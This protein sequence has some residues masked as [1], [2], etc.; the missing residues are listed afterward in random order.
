[1]NKFY[2]SELS[3]RN[4][5]NFYF[6]KEVILPILFLVNKDHK[7]IVVITEPIKEHGGGSSWARL[8]WD[9]L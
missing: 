3:R 7:K 6:L 2:L 1:M 8:Y 9:D 5:E 4:F